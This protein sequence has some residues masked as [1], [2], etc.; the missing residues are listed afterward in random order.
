MKKFLKVFLYGLLVVFGIILLQFAYNEYQ[1]HVF[2]QPYQA[3]KLSSKD[4][5]TLKE[6]DTL[7]QQY[8]GVIWPSFDS[9]DIPAILYNDRYEFMSGPSDDP[10][11]WQ[12]VK[13][14]ASSGIVYYRRRADDPQAFAVE[15]SAGWAGRFSILDRL[16][17]D[18]LMNL[19]RDLPSPLNR[20]LPSQMI[21]KSNDFHIAALVH[22]MFHA[23]QANQAP[24]KFARCN[25]LA[26]LTN[27]Y[28]YRKDTLNNLYSREGRYLRSALR[29]EKAGKKKS[30]C[31]KFLRTRNKR[32]QLLPE[33]MV[34]F[35]K[36]YEWLEGLAKYAEMQ[37]YR[38]AANH[39]ENL[40]FDYSGEMP[41]WQTDRK[42][43]QD[44]G[45][46]DGSTRFYLSGMAQARLLDQLSEDWKNKV[47]KPGIYL[48][49]LLMEKA[50]I[51][52]MNPK[53][54]Q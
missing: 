13:D 49:D 2:D 20:I 27:Q 5:A 46:V 53:T 12:R 15:T 22:E 11:G 24:E 52:A 51:P 40:S 42:N 54:K 50:G 3:K 29:T 43:M 44:L 34:E 21:M 33:K 31:R 37:A 10:D 16:N 23:H 19:R 36:R 35:E 9:T 28:P 39:S 30:L 47:M 18:L 45:G 17:R 1:V 26:H 25:D 4:Q 7:K 32:R 6:L 8:G 14:T 41:H 48:E 38:V